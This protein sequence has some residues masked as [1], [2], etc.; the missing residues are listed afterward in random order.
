M[1][2]NVIAHTCSPS[3]Q[4]SEAGR[5]PENLGVP[6]LCSDVE[7]SLD[8][9]VKFQAARAI[10]AGFSQDKDTRIYTNKQQTALQSRRVSSTRH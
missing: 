7:V 2:W 6:G 1:S 9:I 8:Y 3:N 5:L 4:E 10:Q